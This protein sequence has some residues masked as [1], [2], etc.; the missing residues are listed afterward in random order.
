MEFKGQ[1]PI[2]LLES[3][4][5]WSVVLCC[6]RWYERQC[7]QWVSAADAA[8]RAMKVSTVY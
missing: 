1:G 5:A 7:V 6:V 3:V 8:V 2:P 4:L